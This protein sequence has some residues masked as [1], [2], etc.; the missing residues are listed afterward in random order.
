MEEKLIDLE[1]DIQ[2]LETVIENAWWKHQEN[3]D[4]KDF[5][6]LIN[7]CERLTDNIKESFI[8]VQTSRDS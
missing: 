7:V 3:P 5:D 1:T 4:E 8:K 6:K 2:N